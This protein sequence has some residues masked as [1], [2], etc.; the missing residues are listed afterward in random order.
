METVQAHNLQFRPFIDEA[1]I[2]QRVL[3]LGAE[4]RSKYAGKIPV[5]LSVLNG[6]FIFTADLVRAFE[7]AC[8]VSFIKLA[9]YRGMHSSGDVSKLIG[10]EIDLKNRHVII[11]EDIVDTGR[12]L[13]T[14]LPELE[15]LEPASIEI[16]S[17]LQKPDMLEHPL[18]VNW[19]GF[20]IPSR[21]VI[22]YGLDFD[23]LGRQLSA[24]YQLLPEDHT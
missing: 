22:G 12:T 2:R 9:S 19:V 18:K 21:F 3:E 5:F 20:E 24:V 4:I 10:L 11:V 6:A 7:D 8:E 23:G 14:L 1:T 16:A 13:Y 15:R 17:L